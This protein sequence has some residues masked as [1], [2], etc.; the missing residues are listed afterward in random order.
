MGRGRIET[1]RPSI[2]TLSFTVLILI[3]ILILAGGC[4]NPLLEEVKKIVFPH[5]KITVVDRETGEPITDSTLSYI[6]EGE[7]IKSA[8]GANTFDFALSPEQ[9]CT[10]YIMKDG[11]RGK[12]IVL[13]VEDSDVEMTIGLKKLATVE[14][15]VEQYV[16]GKVFHSDGSSAYTD[17]FYVS[18]GTVKNSI[19]PDITDAVQND[20]GQFNVLAPV[21][22]I[23]VAAFTL[24]NNQEIDQIT[25][26]KAELKEENPLVDLSLSFSDTP[27]F[28]GDKPTD[29]TFRVKL[30][31]GYVL[32]E[33]SAGTGSYSFD[34]RLLS[35]DGVSVESVEYDAANTYFSRKYVG[36]AGGSNNVSYSPLPSIT[37]ASGADYFTVSFTSGAGVSFHETYLLE[38]VDEKPNIP[39]QAV[40][41]AGSEIKMPKSVIDTQ[42][43]AI[44]LYLSAV[45]FPNFDADALLADTLSYDQ[46]SYSETGEDVTADAGKSVSKGLATQLTYEGEPFNFRQAYGFDSLI[47]EQ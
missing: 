15:H 16:Q 1:K 17:V 14:S 24:N 13:G 8:A 6:A 32:A 12:G 10:V 46:Y 37:V 27:T 33:D 40:I 42:A 47:M 43:S 21:G 25:Y 9:I 11:Y 39:F 3:A 29:S 5:I 23:A 35:S 7:V 30:S 44:Y 19:I 41:L 34:I 36:N 31:E 4:E 26:Q 45:S 22:N 2:V 38:I 18:R 20:E 28:S